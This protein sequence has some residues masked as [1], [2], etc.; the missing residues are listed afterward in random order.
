MR[1]RFTPVSPP[2]PRYVVANL[3]N[4]L[5]PKHVALPTIGCNR[6]GDLTGGRAGNAPVTAGWQLVDEMV[7]TYD[8]HLSRPSRDGPCFTGCWPMP[9]TGLIL[10]LP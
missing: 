5:P 9:V 1:M 3:L 4:P 8:V 10:N 6:N 7:F 2:Q